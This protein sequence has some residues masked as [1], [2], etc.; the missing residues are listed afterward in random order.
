MEVAIPVIALGAMYVISNQKIIKKI[1]KL[2]HIKSNK[3][4]QILK[5]L[6]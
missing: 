2:K 3:D 1:F 4:F 6:L 5:H